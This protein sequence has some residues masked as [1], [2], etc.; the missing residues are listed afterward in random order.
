M[1]ERMEPYDW[2][3][4]RIPRELEYMGDASDTDY[5]IY[6][7]VSLFFEER[8]IRR[9][10]IYQ[11]R[12]RK[13]FV[14]ENCASELSTDHLSPGVLKIFGETI[15][16]GVEYKSVLASFR[17]TAQELVKQALDRYDVP[18]EK[19]VD[20]F[21]C[22]VVG[23]VNNSLS[24][25]TDHR[26]SSK[27]QT[28]CCRMLSDHDRPLL[29]QNFWR[30][31]D[32]LSRRY[33]LRR[34]TDFSNCIEGDDT[35]GLNEN[36]RK[37]SISKL[38]PGAIPYEPHHHRRDK[39]SDDLNLN[40]NIRSQSWVA[41]K[42]ECNKVIN[43]LDLDI[44]LASN[45]L[46]SPQLP[47]RQK[48]L[49]LP[50]STVNQRPFLLTIRGFDVKKDPLCHTIC[51]KNVLICN[52]KTS[53]SD[54]QRIILHAPDIQP[55]HC[56]L[57]LK[58]ISNPSERQTYNYT[59]E[60][61]GTPTSTVFI[62]GY[63]VTNRTTLHAGDI[64]SLGKYYIFLFK[65]FS[66]G[67]DIPLQLPW[68]GTDD[69][70]D[71]SSRQF[72]SSFS[73][74]QR[75]FTSG[76]P[77]NVVPPLPLSQE[78]NVSISTMESTGERFRFAYSREKEEDL[79][80]AIGAIVK[81]DFIGFPLAPAYLYSMCIEYSCKR[82]DLHHI[83]NLLLRILG[84][85]RESVGEIS[86]SLSEQKFNCGLVRNKR[87]SSVT[88]DFL[89]YAVRWMSNCVQ[90]I[91]FLR[92]H[93]FKLPF[94]GRK[95]SDD[96]PQSAFRNLATGLEEIVVFCFQQA[97]YA[98]TKAL[99]GLL[100]S[101]LD[102]NPF[103]ESDTMSKRNGM[104]KITSVLDAV[105]R[106]TTTQQLHHDVLKQIFMY[107]F[108]FCSTSIFNKLFQDDSGPVYYNWTAGVRIRTNLGQIEDW[109]QRNGFEEEFT[110][111]SEKLLT[112]AEFLS[113]SKSLLL[114][115]DWMKLKTHFQPLNEAQ[116][117][118][119]VGGYDNGDK[120]PPPSWL[121]SPEDRH[122]ADMKEDIPLEMTAHPPFLIPQDNGCIDLMHPP[123][124][125]TF[126]KIFKDL[127]P[128]YG[129]TEDDSDSGFSPSNTP[130]FSSNFPKTELHNSFFNTPD[131]NR[132]DTEVYRDL[133]QNGDT[134]SPTDISIV[135]KKQFYKLSYESDTNSTPKTS[136][137]SSPKHPPS[138][139]RQESI[140]RRLDLLITNNNLNV[141]ENF[142][143]DITPIE[144]AAPPLPPRSYK[145]PSS[146][147]SPHQLT[148]GSLSLSANSI[149]LKKQL[150]HE[151]DDE[152]PLG[153]ENLAQV[154]RQIYESLG[155][156]SPTNSR[157]P[158][159]PVLGTTV[160]SANNPVFSVGIT[161]GDK[162]LGLGLIDG[163]YT[164]LRL[165]G[166][167]IRKVLPGSPAA[168]IGKI[169]VGDRLLCVNGKSIVG[170]DYQSAMKL[171]RAAGEQL[172]LL[173]AK[174]NESIATKISS[175]SC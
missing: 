84:V 165:A 80:K 142:Q 112:A 27:W 17:S 23:K 158:M 6:S 155:Q 95:L 160:K 68:L 124:D 19:H 79:M 86:K 164:P 78:D 93:N 117:Y 135:A 70:F 94:V 22:D 2:K 98:I 37:I 119:L 146:P 152:D 162:G 26:N 40:A 47:Q 77:Q 153:R 56:Y 169:Q 109:A 100:G 57:H 141:P 134:I 33:E 118:H 90:L 58:R 136:T 92:K 73:N 128:V 138:S 88:E 137:P 4:S 132:S 151:L 120:P 81:Q 51:S 45:G 110:Q 99:Y 173:V 7:P 114:K 74:S 69:V 111:V 42:Y 144:D 131:G 108:F 126:W 25:E 62:N 156:M 130:R 43:S 91:L 9:T 116:L 30:P 115:F 1:F 29:L 71:E 53:T 61:Q 11:G 140:N 102:G 36:A 161:K 82:F 72:S 143:N 21:L 101:V 65:D 167:Y 67:H 31:A 106:L 157:P 148:N 149:S 24:E 46:K 133:N 39:F 107:L 28:K 104:S 66:L 75:D 60:V 38:R 15:V 154:N 129:V 171:I 50:P 3:R 121:P 97:I 85:V 41:K 18:Q 87:N 35:S 123:D 127:H 96:D 44:N 59:V 49:E 14:D 89:K 10:V 166:I 34:K 163:L 139:R 20:Y 170:A 5:E 159:V 168:E 147:T 48:L 83:R 105:L 12:K 145:F 55:R 16:P 125:P 172:T 150:L 76:L 52:N 13:V 122:Q 103:T 175:S 8:E 54:S 63:P 174:G 113:T 64:L 32:G